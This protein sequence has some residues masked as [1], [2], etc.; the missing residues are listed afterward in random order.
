MK[1]NWKA[2]TKEHTQSVNEFNFLVTDTQ[3]YKR[4]CPSLRPLHRSSGPTV[5]IELKS[6]ETRI[7][8]DVI[9]IIC[10]RE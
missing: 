7:F 5:V 6:A 1:R 10:V 9:V 3:L 2:I 8:D 4:L